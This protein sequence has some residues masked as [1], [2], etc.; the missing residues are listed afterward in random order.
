MP[1]A[2]ATHLGTQPQNAAAEPGLQ[3]WDQNVEVFG[4][5]ALG[6]VGEVDEV[7]ALVLAARQRTQVPEESLIF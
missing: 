6:E 7:D 2:S 1:Q 3:R 5:L 4:G